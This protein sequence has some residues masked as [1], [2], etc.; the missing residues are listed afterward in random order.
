VGAF[1]LNFPL[2]VNFLVNLNV[3]DAFSSNFLSALIFFTRRTHG[4]G[5]N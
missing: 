2:L 4:L 3:V 1:K 5:Y